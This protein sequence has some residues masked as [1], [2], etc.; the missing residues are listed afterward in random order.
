VYAN[1]AFEAL[2]TSGNSGSG[3]ADDTAVLSDAVG[4]ALGSV[5][6]A[7]QAPPLQVSK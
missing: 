7:L 6:L 4:N 2:A 3:Y 1:D 5:L